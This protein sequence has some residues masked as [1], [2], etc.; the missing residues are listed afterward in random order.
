MKA[1]GIGDLGMVR[2]DNMCR[3]IA[4]C[5]SVD[6]VKELRDRAKALE[7]YA[8]QARNLDAERKACEIRIRAERR[9]GELLRDM[10]KNGQR[11]AQRDGTPHREA[12]LG[13]SDSVAP[14]QTLA[15][16]NITRDQSS[17]WQQL[18][19]VPAAEF[20]SAVSGDGPKPTTEGI[21]HAHVLRENSQPRMD[22][23][24]LWIW[25]R[26]RDFERNGI[27][28]RRLGEL[29]SLMTDSM[30]D[31]CQRILPRVVEWLTG[32]V[33]DVSGTNGRAA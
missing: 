14:I 33:D 8:Q 19:A 13:K 22:A 4:D 7:V 24:A 17:K 29:L 23:D 32:E 18:A 1:I 3:A 30:R 20:E 28:D 10:A 27:F 21:V 25:G 16:L 31:D 26:F 2:Y 9:A 5:Y 12:R 6:E 11:A 15:D